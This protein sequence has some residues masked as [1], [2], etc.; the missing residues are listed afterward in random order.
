MF[1]YQ[2]RQTKLDNAMIKRKIYEEALLWNGKCVLH[3]VIP[4]P[5]VYYTHAQCTN[6]ISDTW[7]GAE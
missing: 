5:P 7:N 3:D 6:K 1:N 4:S 2:Q